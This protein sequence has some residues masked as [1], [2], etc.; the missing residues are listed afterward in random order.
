MESAL[1]ARPR[2]IACLKSGLRRPEDVV[3]IERLVDLIEPFGPVGCAAPAA[4]IDR[5]FQLAQQARDLS[6]RHHLLHARAGA[7]CLI[8]VVKRRQAAGI[9]F[10]IDLALGKTIDRAEAQPERQF[11]ETLGNELLVAR[12]EWRD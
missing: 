4:L 5:Q 7:E 10:A 11:I 9:E 3:D 12:F 6:L 8:E 2:P 1:R